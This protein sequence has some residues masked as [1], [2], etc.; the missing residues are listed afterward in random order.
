MLIDSIVYSMQIPNVER[1]ERPRQ[2]RLKVPREKRVPCIIAY[3]N[4]LLASIV[5]LLNQIIFINSRACKIRPS[6][7]ES[8]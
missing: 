5:K 2:I 3:V 7:N 6:I 8:R 4:Y 1:V